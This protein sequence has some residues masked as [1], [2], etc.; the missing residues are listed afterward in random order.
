MEGGGEIII[1]IYLQV[2]KLKYRDFSQSHSSEGPIALNLQSSKS[3][4]S[5]SSEDGVLGRKSSKWFLW[6][7]WAIGGC[8]LSS[9]LLVIC[10][11]KARQQPAEGLGL[12]SEGDQGSVCGLVWVQPK[13]EPESRPPDPNP[14][15]S[16]LHLP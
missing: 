11:W 5:L 15:L 1:P 8:D 2:R 4:A 14:V 9:Y 13:Q 16:P 6:L 12:N 7:R 10:G 3:M